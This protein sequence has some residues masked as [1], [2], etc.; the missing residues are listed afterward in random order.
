VVLVI[1]LVNFNVEALILLLDL[2]FEL[3]DFD[4]AFADHVL[5]LDRLQQR[6]QALVFDRQRG[7]LPNERFGGATAFALLRS[8][9]N[10]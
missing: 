2:L 3:E 5:P 4:G 1:N 6:R 9:R 10:F 7:C 8:L